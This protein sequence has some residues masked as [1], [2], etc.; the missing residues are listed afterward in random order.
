M[1]CQSHTN[2]SVPLVVALACC[3]W[4]VVDCHCRLSHLSGTLLDWLFVVL[5]TTRRRNMAR[6]DGWMET[7][8]AMEAVCDFFGKCCVFVYL[9]TPR[10]SLQYHLPA[11]SCSLTPTQTTH[12][13]VGPW[14]GWHFGQFGMDLLGNLESD[15]WYLWYCAIVRTHDSDTDHYGHHDAGHEL[16]HCPGD[17][18]GGDFARVGTASATLG[19]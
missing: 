14:C 1:R 4:P 7:S 3:P 6:I 15:H 8:P 16:G 5:S 18:T 11:G 12:F 17:S 2:H 9:S 19:P 10:S 13:T